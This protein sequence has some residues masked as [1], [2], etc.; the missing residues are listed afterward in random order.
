MIEKIP[1][2][3]EELCF[4]NKMRTVQVHASPY[5]LQVK[6]NELVDAVNNL[7]TSN[8]HIQNDLFKMRHPESKVDT[9]EEQSE[10]KEKYKPWWVLAKGKLC[11]FWSYDDDEGVYCGIRE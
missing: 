6:I 7:Q 8:T 5:D 9:Y 1:F 2:E 10:P 11:K 4:N 3:T